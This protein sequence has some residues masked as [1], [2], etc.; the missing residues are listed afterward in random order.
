MPREREHHG[1]RGLVVGAEDPLVGVFPDTVDEH[2]LDRRLQLH[3]VE[4]CAQQQRALRVGGR[5]SCGRAGG[6]DAGKQVAAVAARQGARA[7]LL[8]AHAQCAELGAD[9]LRAGA[10]AT[11]WALDPAQLG[12]DAAEEAPLE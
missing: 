4:V 6:G 8:N 9:T 2:G 11:G 7:I 12:K 5:R 10:L 3:R 1:D